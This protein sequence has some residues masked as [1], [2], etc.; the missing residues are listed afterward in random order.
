MPL[1]DILENFHFLLIEVVKQVEATRTNLD[2]P[3]NKLI[4]KIHIRDD[5]IDNLKNLIEK[6]TFFLGHDSGGRSYTKKEIDKVIALHVAATNLERIAD[7]AVNIS[8]QTRHLHD[9]TF[10]QDYDYR[11]FFDEI[12]GALN[13]LDDAMNGTD[14]NLALKICR[15]EFKT[16]RMFRK[17]FKRILEELRA[18]TQTENV[19]TTL[20]IFRYLERI[21]DA[22]LNIGEAIISASMGHRLKIEQYS[23]LEETLQATTDADI[24]LGELAYEAFL[25]TRSGA[26]IGKVN[27]SLG[28]DE[29]QGAIF[30]EGKIK[31]I[32]EEKESLEQW[33]RFRPGLTPKVF[34]FQER[35]ANA[36][37]LLEFL[38]G[39]TFQSLVLNLQYDEL[40]TALNRILETLQGLW[41][42]TYRGEPAGARF[43]KQLRSRLPD[44]MRVH[45]ALKSRRRQIGAVLEPSLDDL[46]NQGE[47]IEKDLQAP[48][49]VLIHGDLNIDNIIFRQETDTVHFIDLHRSGMSD[50]VQDVSIFL[51]SNLRVPVY[52]P[53]VRDRLSHASLHFLHWAREFARAHGDTTFDARLSLGLARALATSTRFVMKRTFA[54]ALFLRAMYLLER[55]SKHEGRPWEEYSMPDEVLF[56]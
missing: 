23:A 21:G 24:P 29:S 19:V 15:A 11:L 56:L 25:E 12:L 33:A 4:D 34:D 1:T 6:K 7:L 18:G 16:D 49:S 31:K 38:S 14:V 47:R 51:A 22:L 17:V 40:D 53:E 44:M 10:L 39:S 13:L 52:E 26:R 3:N 54:R 42:E 32:R 28:D 50:Y 46:L 8:K 35:G 55:V 9:K 2:E 30:K 48:F 37:L 20:F 45:P 27:G 5:Y 36:V 43:I 41:E